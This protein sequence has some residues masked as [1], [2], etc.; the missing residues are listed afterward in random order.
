[1]KTI[2]VLV[3]IVFVLLL[4]CRD[5]DDE[6]NKEDI[7][8]KWEVTEMISVESVSYA[9]DNG[10]NP[11]IDFKTDQAVEIK[12]DVNSCFGSFQLQGNNA[13]EIS[14]AGCTEIC[15][16]SDFSVKFVQMLP[17]VS[18]WSF[19]KNVLQLHVSGWGWFELKQFSD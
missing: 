13:I 4:A 5:K 14:D 12:L 6:C 8:G 11:V 1:M 18:S 2:K 15:C 9:K 16:D 19:D 17:Q 3:L 7:I 10:Y